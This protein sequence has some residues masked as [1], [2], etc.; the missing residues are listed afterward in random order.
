MHIRNGIV[1]VDVT[2]FTRNQY[3]RKAG[4][5][6]ESITDP[7]KLIGWWDFTNPVD[8]ELNQTIDGSGTAVTS[9]GDPIR[10]VKNLSNSVNKLG[11]FLRASSNSGATYPEFKTGGCN[12]HSYADF[13]VSGA[14]RL[15][16]TAGTG[17]NGLTYGGVGAASLSSAT[18]NSANQTMFFVITPKDLAVSGPDDVIFTIN[19]TYDGGSN[20]TPD[21]FGVDSSTDD[22]ELVWRYNSAASVG[23]A[24]GVPGTEDPQ[25]WTIQAGS[26]TNGLK[27]YQ[28][29]DQ[30]VGAS[31]TLSANDDYTFASV[32]S[33]ISLGGN[34]TTN[35]GT[36]GSAL[37][38]CH[39]YEVIIY[40]ELLSDT[41]ITNVNNYLLNKYACINEEPVNP[42]I[43]N[44]VGWWDFTDAAS[45]FSDV[46]GTSNVVGQ[47][48]SYVGK[49]MNKAVG[50]SG[51][52]LGR[53]ARTATDVDLEKP[54]WSTGGGANGQPYLELSGPTTLTYGKALMAG[55]FN[56][57]DASTF[58]GVSTT[59]FDNLVLTS[60][61]TTVIMVAKNDSAT[62]TTDEYVFSFRGHT[63]TSATTTG[64][65]SYRKEDTTEDGT[66]RWLA[67][68]S[69][70]EEV[71][72]SAAL[73][74]NTNI[75]MFVGDATAKLYRNGILED[76]EVL[77][78]NETI[79]FDGSNT[80][81]GHPAVS[82]GGLTS[83]FN[84]ASAG[85]EWNGNIYEVH[86]YNKTLS[87]AELNQ[88]LDYLGPKYGIATT[89][90]T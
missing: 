8:S 2:G 43:S 79:D 78:T 49:V 67:V 73:D 23:L 63:T 60:Q 76:T 55:Y 75:I 1:L 18:V 42:T 11:V 31:S 81:A 82:I 46:A 25:I 41:E 22:I 80:S 32:G 26:G 71:E 59:L 19:K 52:K 62:V 83:T 89:V 36:G 90:I 66:A 21:K 20:F 34:T 45:V 68:G 17:S 85:T 87:T 33:R 51:N 72:T 54:K 13:T 14:P 48:V 39:V 86:V 65:F 53:F 40:D 50:D 58:G 6:V 3:V 27:F 9:N 7:D 28:N 64:R 24:S 10:Y 37:Y 12:G 84:K 57:E 35:D 56:G 74:T 61:N 70:T 69:T 30:S 47:A 15:F 16:A 5:P 38:D 88:M 29:G 4:P 44:H 77:G